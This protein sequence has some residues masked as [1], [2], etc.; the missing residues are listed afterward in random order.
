[1]LLGCRRYVLFEGYQLGIHGGEILSDHLKS[2]QPLS[3]QNRPTI[4]AGILRSSTLS[5]LFRQV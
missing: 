5:I 4:G 1:M 3:L 2:G